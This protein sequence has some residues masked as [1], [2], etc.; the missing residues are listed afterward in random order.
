MSGEVETRVERVSI[1]PGVSV[2]SVLRYLNYKPWFALAEFVD[3]AVQ[4]YL[5]NYEA[6]TLADDTTQR[7]RVSIEIDNTPPGR[8][9]I[10]DNAAGIAGPDFPRAF[11]PAVVPPDA[12]GL[13]EFGMGMKSAACWFSSHWRV[14]TKAFGEAI[15]RTVKFDIERIVNDDLEELDIQEVL[16]KP[17]AHY[18]E[19]VLEGLHHVP[20]GRTIGKI[21][22]HLTDIYRVFVRNGTLDLRLNG[23]S[24][25]YESPAILF[26]PYA[27][28]EGG[29]PRT[30]KKEISFDLGQGQTVKGFAALRDP[31]N[32]SRSGFAL[33]R[34]GRLIQGSGEDGYRPQHIFLHHGSYR[35]L[36][37]FGELELEGFEVSHTKDGFRW[38]DED[39]QPFLELLRE[40]LDSEDLPLL[41]QA[42]AYRALATKRDR[43][44]AATKALDRTSK[45]IE[46]SMPDVL[47]RVAEATPIE[48]R[49]LPLAPQSTLARRELNLK[50]RGHIWIIRIEL[51]NDPAEGDWLTVSDQQARDS[52]DAMLEIR[53]AMTHPFMVL[54]AQTDPDDIEA[55]VRVGAAIAISEKLARRAGVKMA[56]TI[57]RNVNEILREALSRP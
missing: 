8:I 24:L 39:E 23:D 15:E 56:G 25:V 14:R 52:G 10:R 54:F 57:R 4:S 3:N 19:I 49:E 20:V 2:L 55:L 43:V 51:S 28:E 50:F 41:K 44:A 7:L 9:T 17:G 53:I 16:A 13:S 12:S 45:V 21:K 1:R 46:S 38:N 26:A 5:S 27:R 32:H 48:T 35:Y 31:G 42:D 34:R 47:P 40:H 11:R 29:Q 6:L 18:T 36:R 30:W 22:E 37:L 33:F